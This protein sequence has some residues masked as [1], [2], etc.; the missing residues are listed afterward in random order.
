[1]E[2]RLKALLA[3][4]AGTIF[5]FG[6]SLSGMTDPQKVIGFLDLSGRW[7]PT[8]GFVM[9]GAL[10]ITF[11]A[12]AL[13]RRRRAPVLDAKFYLPTQKH[14]DRR[15]L[16]GAAL[17]GIGWGVAGFC[18]GPAI[19]SLASGSPIVIAFVAAMIGGMLLANLFQKKAA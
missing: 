11:P 6:L 3:L 16:I 17:F 9:G 19:A 12:F 5:G 13:I 10:L 8:L 1:M 4:L 7:Q 14:I 2:P 18:P 15:L